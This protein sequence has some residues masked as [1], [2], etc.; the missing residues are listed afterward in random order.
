MRLSYVISLFFSIGL[1]LARLQAQIVINEL[2]ADNE[3][4]ALDNYGES[5]DWLEL[6]NNSNEYTSLANYFL[7][8]DISAPQ[9]WE[10]PNIS[11][12]PQ[13]R[14]LV[15]AS[16]KDEYGSSFHTNFKLSASGEWLL[17]YKEDEGIVD[18]FNFPALGTDQSV[19]RLTD[20]NSTWALF[21][22]PTPNASNTNGT[23]FSQAPLWTTTQQFFDDSQAISLSHP[24][25]GTQIFFS[26][27]G[28][29][30]DSSSEL[31]TQPI[32]L[33]TTTAIRAIAYSPNALASAVISRT[34]FIKDQHQLPIVSIMGE[35]KDY[36]SWES[37]IFVDGGPNASEEWPYYGSNYWLDKD[38][39]S[40]IEYFTTEKE[41][42]LA[43]QAD[44]KI[45]GGRGSRTQPMK[46]I[47]IMNKK[48]YGT[49]TIDYPFFYNRERSTFTN[50]VLRNA[51]G[52]YNV[53]HCRDP[54]L[55]RYYIDQD[56]NVDAVAYQAVVVYL[57]GAYYGVENLRERTDEHYVEHNY[58]IPPENI[59]LLDRDTI[60]VRGDFIAFDSMHNYVTTHDL[61][62]ATE[63]EQATQYFD[64]YNIAEGFALQSIVNNADWLH[65]NIRYW[66][67]RDDSSRW[68][69][70]LFDLD[71][72]LGRYLWSEYDQENY[73]NLL[74]KPSYNDSNRH[75]NIFKAFLKNEDY[76]NYFLNR[77]A[78]LL[79]T[80]FRP[81]IL[82]H[83]IDRTLA[84]LDPEMPLHFQR[85]PSTSYDE[86]KNEHSPALYEYI[87]ERPHFARQHLMDYYEL[88]NEIELT[89]STYP[90]E[91]GRIHINS[92]TPEALPWDGIYFN[93]VPVSVRIEANAGYEFSHWQSTY[94]VTSPDEA[95][96]ITYNF[97]Q[98][99]EL[100]AYF[101]N[102]REALEVSSYLSPNKELIVFLA[103]QEAS[104]LSFSIF[105]AQGRL[106]QK[107]GQLLFGGGQ[108]EHYMPVQALSAGA[109]F[110]EITSDTGQQTIKFIIPH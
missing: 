11:L 108:Q 67:K 32:I 81:E 107:S 47:R 27:D 50:L 43:W 104:Q 105:D 6:Y 49:P 80:A 18:Q 7:S 63:F 22:T 14:L 95:T 52:D 46:S 110:L 75:V 106:L 68:R 31:Y 56:F 60:V 73:A 61:S 55:S 62:I 59:D 88:P 10:L 100:V 5:P 76:K 17:L 2:C 58:G 69:Y 86:W 85:W 53:A 42:A 44:I 25:A 71:N 12:A 1:A 29:T 15:F 92:I 35:P 66:R 89:L 20:G 109:Y 65:N 70:I 24:V 87:K 84:E 83:E 36:W 99:D 30:P 64:H 8:D 26:R 102:D 98:D 4:S 54:L 40:H 38:V 51:S 39:A 93:G 13:A 28:S 74:D 97:E 90:A 16:G 19:G 91:A 41:L 78:D 34:Y 77:Y 57:N 72:A 48:K 82:K 37:G 9:K 33:D 94:T 79:N 23:A 96:S 3:L 45:H 103:L 101:K 21:D